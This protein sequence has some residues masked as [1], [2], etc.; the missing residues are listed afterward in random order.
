MLFFCLQVDG[1]IPILANNNNNNKNKQTNHGRSILQELVEEPCADHN[2][3]HLMLNSNQVMRY[4]QDPLHDN[5]KTN[6]KTN[7]ISKDTKVISFNLHR[8]T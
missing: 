2:K 4:A 1:P 8:H 7:R 5:R 6:S 3:Q